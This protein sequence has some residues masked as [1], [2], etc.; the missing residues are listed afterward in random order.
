MNR[1]IVDENIENV[2]RWTKEELVKIMN[3]TILITGATGLI[4]AMMVKVFVNANKKYKLNNIIIVMVRN[5]EK[6][7]EIFCEYDDLEIVGLDFHESGRTE[8]NYIIHAASPTQSEFLRNQP[9]EVMDCIVGGT[10]EV[11]GLSLKQT[12][13]KKF[14]Y[15]SSMEAYGVCD[16]IVTENSVGAID[17]NV[18]RSSYPI[19][20][21]VAEFYGFSFFEEYKLPV[22]NARLAMCLG[23]REFGEDERAAASF[24]KIAARGNDIELKTR[25]ETVLNFVYIADLAVGIIKLMVNGK[26]GEIYNIVSDD[27]EKTIFDLA[28]NIAEKY[29]VGVKRGEKCQGLNGEYAPEN[30]MILDNKKMKD[31]GWCPK[32]NMMDSIERLAQYYNDEFDVVS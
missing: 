24:I 12:K 30:R 27:K 31:I 4:G 18:S 10:R 13:M 11:L 8:I 5:K 19:G 28:K 26:D 3:S 22:V 32:Y 14:V 9:V 6:A 29:G 25:G 2:L 21:R 15:L 17:Y 16:G 1:H 7:R 23:P 20:K